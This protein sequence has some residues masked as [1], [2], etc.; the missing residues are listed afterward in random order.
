VNFANVIKPPVPFLQKPLKN[1]K[2]NLCNGYVSFS[3][4][5]NEPP[6]NTTREAGTLKRLFFDEVRSNS[7]VCSHY[8]TEY[9]TIT[10]NGNLNEIPTI[11]M[12]F[13]CQMS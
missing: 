6:G 9:V 5:C 13:Y 3:E 11:K 8:R 12:W 4:Q 7:G 10:S 2:N 1:Y